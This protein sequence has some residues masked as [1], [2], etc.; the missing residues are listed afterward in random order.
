M[1]RFR[2]T[3]NS[4][5]PDSPDM[6]DNKDTANLHHLIDPPQVSQS[7]RYLQGQQYGQNSFDIQ[8]VGFGLPKKDKVA[9]NP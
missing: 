4:H 2:R 3:L 8:N 5:M 9:V 7:L 6:F 1:S